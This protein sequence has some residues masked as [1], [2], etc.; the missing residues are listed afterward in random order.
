L[1]ARLTILFMTRLARVL[2][3]N[4]P[5]HV[6]QRGNARQYVFESD[7]DRL[8]YLDLLRSHCQ[9]QQLSLLGYCL[10]SNHVHLIVVPARPESL[11]QALKHAHGR[12]ATYFNARHAASGH[13]WQGRY[14]SC[15]MDQPHLWAALRYTELNPVRA[16][17]VESPED[18]VWSSARAHCGLAAAPPW[19]DTRA[20]DAQWDARLWRD[21]LD[22][23]DRTEA[24]AIRASTHTGRPLGSTEFVSELERILRRRLV[25][26]KGGRPPKQQP[27]TDQELLFPQVIPAGKSW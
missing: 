27:N 22:R 23:F 10:M 12:Y 19:L 11:P 6:T 4:T 16:R 8:V 3:A 2:S 13:V 17:M 14:Y 9:I 26:Q 21:Y 7:A 20:F 15:A 1:A 25:P 5:F 24:D 18:H